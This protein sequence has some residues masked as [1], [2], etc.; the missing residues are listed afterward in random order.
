MT[1]FIHDAP[2]LL[3]LIHT[4]LL[5][6][7][8]ETPA[9]IVTTDFVV[10]EITDVGPGGNRV[11]WGYPGF[12]PRALHRRLIWLVG[13]YTPENLWPVR[14]KGCWRRTHVCPV[15][16]ASAESIAGEGDNDAHSPTPTTPATCRSQ[17]A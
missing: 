13:D 2:I 4:E 16:T 10:R 8:L 12:P 6:L 15:K 1:V 11:D 7:S 14:L 17:A 3:D 9:V 5:Q